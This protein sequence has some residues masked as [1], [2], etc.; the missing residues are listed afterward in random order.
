MDRQ[1]RTGGGAKM[2]SGRP[3]EPAVDPGT[4]AAAADAHS[5]QKSAQKAAIGPDTNPLH[6]HLHMSEAAPKHAVL[7]GPHMHPTRS[8]DETLDTA[9]R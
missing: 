7:P 6:A 1:K 3:S 2:A 5:T 4:P 9:C 8:Y